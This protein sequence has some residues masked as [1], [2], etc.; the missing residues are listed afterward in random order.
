MS[1]NDPASDAL[2]GYVQQGRQNLWVADEHPLQLQAYGKLAALECMLL[3][4]R[5]D[6]YLCAVGSKL[7]AKFCDFELADFLDPEFE[8]PQRVLFRVAKEKPLVHHVINGAYR[9]LPELGSLVISGYKREGVKSYIDKTAALFRCIPELENGKSQLTVA[10]FRKESCPEEPIWL[11]D[12]DYAVTRVIG[13]L[14]DVSVV[15]KPGQYGWSKFDVGSRL[16]V[17]EI[18]AAFPDR[19]IGSVL[20]LGCGYG[21]LS[22]AIRQFGVGRIVATDNCAAALACCEK[23]LERSGFKDY[24][25]VPSDAGR[26]I[27]EKFDAI[28]CNPPFHQGFKSSSELTIRF[29]KAI[30]AHLKPHGEAWF[31]VNQFIPLQPLA[32]EIGL[33]CTLKAQKRGFRVF[34]MRLV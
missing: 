7:R 6:V 34:Q 19:G 15:S 13:E 14:D 23:N 18:A 5:F 16:L 26:E 32:N 4:N 27:E 28:V 12:S 9:A 21:F 3:T 17:E 2:L 11:D 8:C 24:Q 1:Y 20:D 30:P 29:L 33:K 10:T 22:L 31:V 25:V